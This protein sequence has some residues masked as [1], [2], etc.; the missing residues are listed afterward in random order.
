MAKRDIVDVLLDKLTEA[1]R[2][3][4]RE[5]STALMWDLIG[6]AEKDGRIT[7]EAAIWFRAHLR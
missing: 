2:E 6:R 4:E 1:T 5:K 7:P 3:N